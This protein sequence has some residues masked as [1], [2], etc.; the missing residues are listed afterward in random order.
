MKN[1]LTLAQIKRQDFVDNSIFELIEKLN[2]TGENV[3]T[4][5]Y[6]S[7]SRIRSIVLSYYIDKLSINYLDYK[8]IN[9]LEMIFYPHIDEVY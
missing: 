8:Q 1:E 5:D 9:A 3:C 7:I 4:Y 2:P 6:E